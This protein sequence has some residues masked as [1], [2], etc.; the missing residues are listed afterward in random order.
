MSFTCFMTPCSP[1][2][3]VCCSVRYL[4][5]CDKCCIEKYIL[6]F[7]R[8]AISCD[9]A[10]LSAFMSFKYA[11]MSLVWFFTFS[12]YITSIHRRRWFEDERVGYWPRYGSQTELFLCRCPIRSPGSE[13]L[14]PLFSLCCPIC[15]KNPS[16]TSSV[17]VAV[18]AKFEC[19]YLYSTVVIYC[20]EVLHLLFHACYLQIT[21][22]LE[23]SQMN[24]AM[25]LLGFELA[26]IF[27]FDRWIVLRCC[28]LTSYNTW[29]TCIS[30]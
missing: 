18:Y 19:E 27:R 21:L 12:T 16:N 23:M 5:L 25:Y 29:W 22:E 17:T 20:G 30:P 28:E 14:K 2:L 4:V 11:T 13:G 8:T 26:W 10:P 9:S 24:M 6:S 1:C 7:L 15:A 3:T